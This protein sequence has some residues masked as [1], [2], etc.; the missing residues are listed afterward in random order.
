M[1]G[2]LRLLPATTRVRAASDPREN[3]ERLGLLSGS[4]AAILAALCEIGGPAMW[5]E[6][7]ALDVQADLT[8]IGRVGSAI[9]MCDALSVSRRTVARS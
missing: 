9:P 8:C 2:A 5:I 4:Y 7:R 3:V 6:A 1:S